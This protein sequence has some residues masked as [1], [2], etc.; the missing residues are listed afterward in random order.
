MCFSP[1][2]AGFGDVSVLY[3]KLSPRNFSPSLIGYFLATTLFFKGIGVV[4]GL[5]I[6]TK[7]F[8]M[9][10]YSIAIVGMLSSMAASI[11]LGFAT[12]KWMMFIGMYVFNPDI[13]TLILATFLKQSI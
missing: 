10:D 8:K 11:Y 1:D 2:F 6:L 13:M 7:I 12:T 3:S 4:V 5:P 9:S